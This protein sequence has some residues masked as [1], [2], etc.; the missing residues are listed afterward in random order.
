MKKIPYNPDS[1]ESF[2]KEWLLHKKCKEWWYATGILFDNEQNMYSYQYTMISLVFGP[3]TVSLG[4]VSYTH[5]TL[6]TMAVV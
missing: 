2:D 5:L 4:T 6:P 3:A 1:L